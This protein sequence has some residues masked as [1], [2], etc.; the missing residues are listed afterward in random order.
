MEA[1]G[2]HAFY[3][4]ARAPKSIIHSWS[5][6]IATVLRIPDLRN[7]MIALGVQPTGTTPEALS[8]IMEAD[9]RYWRGI[10]KAT[11]FTAQ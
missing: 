2:W 6:S 5:A 3:A 1:L 11:G 8:A 7:K 4:S 10:I 9:T